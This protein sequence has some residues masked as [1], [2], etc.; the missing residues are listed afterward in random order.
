[1]AH[2]LET[3]FY[4]GAT[5]WHGLG[6]YVGDEPVTSKE[7][8]VASGL[9]W[10]VGMQPLFVDNPFDQSRI[11][12]SEHR[13]VMR[14]TDCSILGVAGKDY[15]PVQNWE[16]FEFMDSL[17]ETGELRYH[18]AG[19]LRNGKRV[20]MLAKF[21]SSVI[22][23]S[24]AVDKY[25]F[26]WNTHDSSG[27]IRALFTNVRVVCANT[28]RMALNAA[29]GEGVYLKHTSGIKNRLEQAR[30][31]LGLAHKQSVQFDEFAQSLTKLRMT[32]PMWNEY[33][34]V[35]VPKRDDGMEVSKRTS[36]MRANVIDT[37]TN[38]YEHGRGQEIPGVAG[39]GW[40]AYN[41][42]TEYVNYH[43]QTRGKDRAQELRFEGS[44]LGSGAALVQRG[45]E[46]LV[47]FLRA[48]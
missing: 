26:L 14:M 22:L 29:H 9:D 37:L 35:L 19:S 46:Q 32:T 48:A 38:L 28:A 30:N 7:A 23:P 2:E 43:R 36:S 33:C 6:T 47:Q 24:D 12:V 15:V 5:P 3:S 42:T 41:A 16:A 21:G 13:C 20:W 44:L 4:V 8:I 31:V 10:Q 11:S 1:M 25:L 27:A 45:T 17:V 39:T 34:E 18:T 40:A